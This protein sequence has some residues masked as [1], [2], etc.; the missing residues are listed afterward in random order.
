MARFVDL[1]MEDGADDVPADYPHAQPALPN[2]VSEP[3]PIL[4]PVNDTAMARAF[5]CYPYVLVVVYLVY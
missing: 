2:G 3:L 4:A 5:Q 1:E